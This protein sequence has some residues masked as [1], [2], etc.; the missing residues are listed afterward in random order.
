MGMEQEI[1]LRARDGADPSLLPE[2]PALLPLRCSP[3]ESIEMRTTYYDTEE[4]ILARAKWA[5]RCPDGKRRAI[6]T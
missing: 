4:H 5:L 3:M 6:I 1:K 2:D